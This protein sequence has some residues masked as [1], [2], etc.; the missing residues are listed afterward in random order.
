[1]NSQLFRTKS[2]DLLISEADEPSKRLKKTLGWLSLTALGIGAIIGSGIFVTTGTAAAGEIDRYP[3]ILQAPL[4]SVLM[5]GT[6]ALITGRPGAGPGIA[7]SFFA[8]AL[9]C[10]LAGLCYAELASM[11]PI[12]GSAYTYT[13]A[14]LGEFIAWIIGWDLILEYA[15]SNMAV[16]VGFSAYVNNLLDTFHLH[17]PDSL[18]TPAYDPTTNGWSL[19]FNLLAFVIVMFL[20]VLLVRGIRE[21]AGANNIMVG[22]KLLAIVIFCV[23]AGKYIQ[24]ANLKPFFP[25][26]FQGVLTGGALVFFS[27]M[28]F[29][30]VSTAAEECRNPKRDVP[31]GILASLFVCAVFYVA[32]A[33]VLTGIQHWDTLNNAAP[34]AQALEAIGLK[35]TDR[36]VTVGALMGMIS[37]ILVYQIGQARIWFAMSRDGLLPTVFSRVHKVFR[38]PDFGTWVAGFFVAIPAGIFNI[39]TLV[40]LSSIGTLFA[41]ILV[42]IAVLVLRKHQP[43][44]PR[45]F[46]VPFS[47]WIPIASVVFCFVL[48]ASLDVENWV[49]FFVWLII[50]LLFYFDFGVR[51]STAGRAA[52]PAAQRNLTLMADKALIALS[53]ALLILAIAA[54]GVVLG[55]IVVAGILE[56]AGLV[57]L[58]LVALIFLLRGWKH[59]RED[60]PVAEAA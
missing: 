9:V 5:H 20:T 6:H 35:V 21:S 25:N 41:F 40:N 12:A 34:V 24:P 53:A 17:I 29:D 54:A 39:G 49:R 45:G 27:Y 60:S 1:M 51:H 32:V 47:P 42:S 30:S 18:G 55:G 50:G 37:S 33:V 36:W 19:H 43:D 22:I 16:A 59:Y 48:M 38:T 28:G 4:L 31:I 14:T 57:V 26:G 15:V 2:I 3:S 44:R 8:V 46:R 11:I 10:G 56:R 7:V 58:A 13:Y 23:V 52:D